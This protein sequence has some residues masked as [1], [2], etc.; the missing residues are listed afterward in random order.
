MYTERQDDRYGGGV[1]SKKREGKRKGGYLEKYP[2]FDWQ[3]VKL[4]EKWF[5]VHMSAFA[6][7]YFGYM[8]VYF[9]KTVHFDKRG[10]LTKSETRLLRPPPPPQPVHVSCQGDLPLPQL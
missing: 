8:I 2:F 9:L 4:F 7:N 5:S 10:R 3:P 6:E 1:P